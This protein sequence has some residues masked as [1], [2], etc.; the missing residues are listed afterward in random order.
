MAFVEVGFL[1]IVSP[2]WFHKHCKTEQVG[3]IFECG[4][5]RHP[6]VAAAFFACM[7]TKSFS[8]ISLPA[9]GGQTC[10]GKCMQPNEET[11]QIAEG[12]AGDDSW[13]GFPRTP[14]CKHFSEWRVGVATGTSRALWRSFFA[15]TH[16]PYMATDTLYL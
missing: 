5:G 9:T 14:R 1:S 16:I 12:M 8:Q 2:A 11:R 13:P 3:M 7:L 6:S 15:S 10:G 4:K